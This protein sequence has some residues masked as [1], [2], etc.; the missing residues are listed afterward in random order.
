MKTR[1]QQTVLL[2]ELERCRWIT[3]MLIADECEE[4]G[5]AQ[6]AAGWRWL[7]EHRRWPSE[8][9]FSG[10]HR[11]AFYVYWGPRHRPNILP[12]FHAT[13]EGGILA[14]QCQASSRKLTKLLDATAVYMGEMLSPTRKDK[15]QREAT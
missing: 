1:K 8:S 6:K 5:E 3:M 11:W 13:S 4:N 12:I 10:V 9:L 7:C 2:E 15:W 14:P